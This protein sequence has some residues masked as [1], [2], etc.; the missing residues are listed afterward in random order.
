MPPQSR[1]GDIATGHGCFPPNNITSASGNVNINSRGAARQG[2]ALSV[3]CCGPSCHGS[4]IV[5]SSS[6]VN[7]NSR[8]A[9]R[10]TDAIDCGEFVAEGSGNV[11][12][13]G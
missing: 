1:L 3:H 8:G 13:G 6:T 2:D 9:A 5:G 7:I 10:V 11:I 12:T 4:S